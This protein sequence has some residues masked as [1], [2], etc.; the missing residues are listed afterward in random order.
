MAASFCR[1]TGSKASLTR[2]WYTSLP[3][4]TR[5]LLAFRSASTLIIPGL[6]TSDLAI[7][8]EAIPVILDPA[9]AEAAISELTVMALAIAG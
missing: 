8:E 1:N 9:I 6:A 4:I 5:P 7:S 3:V 2:P